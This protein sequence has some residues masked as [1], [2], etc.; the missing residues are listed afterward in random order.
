MSEPKFDHDDTDA[1]SM[2][3]FLAEEGAEKHRRQKRAAE[4]SER[5]LPII[6]KP[7][8]VSESGPLLPPK[9]GAPVEPPPALT[10]GSSVVEDELDFLNDIPGASSDGQQWRSGTGKS[11]PDSDSNITRLDPR[12]RRIRSEQYRVAGSVPDPV[13]KAPLFTGDDF[14]DFDVGDAP[15]FN[16]GRKGV[17]GVAKNDYYDNGLA[18][19]RGRWLLIALVLIAAGGGPF[20]FANSDDWRVLLQKFE[21]FVSSYTVSQDSSVGDPVGDPDVPPTVDGQVVSTASPLMKRFRK[22]L[23]LVEGLVVDGALDDAEKAL[24][25]MDRTVYGYGA[26][27]FGDLESRIEQLRSGVVVVDTSVEK[28]ARDEAARIADEQAAQA[29]RS[30]AARIA[31]AADQ[32]AQEQRARRAATEQSAREEQARIAAQRSARDEQ[33]RVAAQ[34]A[35]REEQARETAENARQQAARLEQDRQKEQARLDAQTAR[36]S[37]WPSVDA[38]RRATDRRIAEER[39]AVQRQ[40]AREQRL[41]EA[42]EREAALEAQAAS[43]K[44]GSESN[45]AVTGNT[46][47][48]SRTAAVP[49][50]NTVNTDDKVASGPRPIG[51]DELQTVYRRFIDLQQAVSNRDINAVVGLTQRSGARVQQLMQIFENSTQIDARIRS[52]STSNATGQIKGTL[53][54][55]RIKR[56]DGTF[57]E[58]PSALSSIP[59]SSQREGDGWSAISW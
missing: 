13:S 41:I 51:D 2:F 43:Q 9:P 8:P 56:A 53:Q 44:S 49:P 39:A 30:E 35:A 6:R 14:D 42:R 57:V 48:T 37:D 26:A 59:L 58:P 22:Q 47:G 20:L 32:A 36:T 16:R 19:R 28:A 24:S 54:I 5:S 18:P 27:E 34:Q 38:D 46:A 15:E 1:E 21:T 11:D 7:V 52:V 29:A 3:D 12:S 40:R 31:A 10:D 45:A 50:A 55:N 4:V 17:R 23:I 25:S 33:A